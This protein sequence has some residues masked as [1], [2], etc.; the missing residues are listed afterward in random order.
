ML[1]TYMKPIILIMLMILQVCVN[2]E[3][4]DHVGQDKCAAI[5]QT[6]DAL[7]HEI[8][9]AGWMACIHRTY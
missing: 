8:M 6:V 1:I 3:I 9:H 5:T 2:V 4:E 7:S